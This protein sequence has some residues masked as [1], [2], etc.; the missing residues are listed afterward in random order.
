ML[1][2]SELFQHEML[3]KDSFTVGFVVVVVVKNLEELVSP[4]IRYFV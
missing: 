1:R 2:I 3:S 4:F